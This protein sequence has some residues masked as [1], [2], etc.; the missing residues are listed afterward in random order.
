M[1]FWKRLLIGL[2]G[3]LVVVTFILILL[4]YPFG[5]KS[6]VVFLDAKPG[7][8]FNIDK[9]K[10]DD[11]ENNL[12]LASGKDNNILVNLSPKFKK[13]ISGAGYGDSDPCYYAEWSNVGIWSILTIY[14]DDQQCEKIDEEKRT[15]IL[16]LFVSREIANRMN[17]LEN[18]NIFSSF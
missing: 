1:A 2:L 10:K 15:K 8:S 7:F 4:T 3:L 6:K 12:D 18:I 9:S 17:I 5:T 13:T 11:F 16:K 14:M